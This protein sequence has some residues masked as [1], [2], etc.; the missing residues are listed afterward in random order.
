[1]IKPAVKQLVGKRIAAVIAATCN[2]APK[3]LLFFVFDDGTYYE[4]YSSAEISTAGGVDQGGIPEVLAYLQR[5]QAE[6]V[7]QAVSPS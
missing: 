2:V 6:I 7:F 1:M 4:F 5:M 3:T